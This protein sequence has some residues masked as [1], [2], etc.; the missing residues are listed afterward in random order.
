MPRCRH[1]CCT[2]FCCRWLGNF[3]DRILPTAF[4][5]R[6]VTSPLLPA[7]GW[8]RRSSQR[9]AGSSPV[10]ADPRGGLP[11]RHAHRR[12][13]FYRGTCPSL[14]CPACCLHACSRCSLPSATCLLCLLSAQLIMLHS[15]VHVA[16]VCLMLPAVQERGPRLLSR[17]IKSGLFPGFQFSRTWVILRRMWVLCAVLSHVVCPV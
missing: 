10:H 13:S 4:N 16:H 5:S 11:L 12:D 7:A 17:K 14:P 15:L 2:G 6:V 9:D 1:T 3:I 8:P